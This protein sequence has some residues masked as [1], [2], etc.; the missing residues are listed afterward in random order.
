M[1]PQVKYLLSLRAIRDRAAI[2]AEAAKAKDL[3]FF[4]VHEDKLDA[5]AEYVASVIE[6]SF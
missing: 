3:E 1:D 4:D 6:V 5:V 2:V